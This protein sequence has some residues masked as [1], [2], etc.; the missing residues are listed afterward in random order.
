MDPRSQTHAAAAESAPR[1]PVAGVLGL[2]IPGLGLIVRG[3]WGSG[4]LT[5]AAVAHCVVLGIC[6]L[7]ALV[8][9]GDV[10][11]D[12]TAAAVS[13]LKSGILS[14]QA[15]MMWALALAVH[16]GAAWRAYAPA[17]PAKEGHALAA[18]H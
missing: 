12:A 4:V 16:L 10:A 8:S 2:L 18:E 14:P 5:L 17:L 11:D 6:S 13:A 9:R 15:A 3:Q 1:A 7:A